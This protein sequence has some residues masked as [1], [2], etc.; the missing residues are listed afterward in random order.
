MERDKDTQQERHG[1]TKAETEMVSLG[2][3]DTGTARSHQQLGDGPGT[4]SP[5]EPPERTKNTF[6]FS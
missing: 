1:D 4:D 3:K 5:S 2:A 6:L